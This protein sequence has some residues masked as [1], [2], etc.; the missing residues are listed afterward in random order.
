MGARRGG[1]EQDKDLQQIGCGGR[2]LASGP[3]EQA[4]NTVMAATSKDQILLRIHL[5]RSR[6]FSSDTG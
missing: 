6:D 1:W 2:W 3:G 4:T 5:C